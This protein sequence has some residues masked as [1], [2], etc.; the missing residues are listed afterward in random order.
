MLNDDLML[1]KTEPVCS[2]LL[3]EKSFGREYSAFLN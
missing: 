1:Q 3:M 2:V